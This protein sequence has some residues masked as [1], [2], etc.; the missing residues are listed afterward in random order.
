REIAEHRITEGVVAG[1][2]L[3]ATL[4][5]RLRTRRAQVHQPVRAIDGERLQERPVE[6]REDRGVGADAERQRDDGHCRDELGL[7]ER[8]EREAKTTHGLPHVMD[9]GWA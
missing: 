7:E 8:P 1:A 9:G 5:A 6:E 3:A 2:R 4:R